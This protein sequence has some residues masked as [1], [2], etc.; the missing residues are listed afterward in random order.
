M[1]SLSFCE[2]L[3]LGQSSERVRVDG[4]SDALKIISPRNV[5]LLGYLVQGTVLAF[6]NDFNY[7]DIYLGRYFHVTELY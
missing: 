2:N 3:P 6:T 4:R 5:L 7:I 1:K